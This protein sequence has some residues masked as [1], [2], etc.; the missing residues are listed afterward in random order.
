MGTSAAYWLS[1]TSKTRII[2]LD[3]YTIGNDYC[4]SND[5]NRV[6]RYSYG[7][8][9]LYTRMAVESLR[10]WKR[11]EQETGQTLLLPSGLLLVQGENEEANRFNE[12]TY[13]TLTRMSLDAERLD[14]YDLARRFPQ[15]QASNAILDPHGGVLLASKALTTLTTTAKKQ[16]V[17]I[18]ENHKATAVHVKGQIEIETTQQTIRC[19]KAIITTGPWS[20]SLQG[21]GLPKITPTRQQIIYFQPTNL[22][23]FQP[24]RFPVFFVD[25]Y[26]GIPAAGTNSVKV[27]HKGL[28]D[29]VAPD[30]ANRKID[31]DTEPTY[32]KVCQRYIPELANTPVH[33]T[34]VC[35]YDMAQNSDFIITQD[36]EY[37]TIT[38]AYGFSGHGFKFAPLIGKLLAQLAQGQKPSFD[39][40]RFTP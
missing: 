23:R 31:P 40:E 13:N 37:P 15:F 39:L 32:R 24:N 7:K 14:Q 26:Y 20:N 11:L 9:E 12:E 34:K 5:A 28:N 3:Q 19:R 1:K 29:P 33:S 16:G 36:P 21:K 8:D 4:S 30:K 18:L 2:L 38:H 27:S 10:L 25:Q 35:L 17:T 22:D 6:F